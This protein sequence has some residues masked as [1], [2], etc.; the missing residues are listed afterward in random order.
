MG[1]LPGLGGNMKFE[2]FGL[3]LEKQVASCW[4]QWNLFHPNNDYRVYGYIRHDV[5]YVADL[6][7]IDD[8]EWTYATSPTYE[9]FE[10]AYQ[11]L[12]K[13]FIEQ[14]ET[15]RN[16]DLY[17]II[18]TSIQ[19]ENQM[20]D[21]RKALEEGKAAFENTV[22]PEKEF[23][24]ALSNMY[25]GLQFSIKFYN[26]YNELYYTIVARDKD[27]KDWPVKSYKKE[28][29]LLQ[30]AKSESLHARIALILR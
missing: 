30:L 10:E 26:Q 22:H 15:F 11:F 2:D 25:P 17:R 14:V 27:G 23:L 18:T 20:E 6:Q 13:G 7:V 9:T 29:E 4:D 5:G 16:T 19:K 21:Y 3:V 24:Q 8:T 12:L 1:E 28:E